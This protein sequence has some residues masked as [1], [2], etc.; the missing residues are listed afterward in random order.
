MKI[1]IN[2]TLSDALES[3]GYGH[4]PSAKVG[5]RDI[6]MDG[7]VVSPG[8]LCSSAWE[9]L[10]E[11]HPDAFGGDVLEYWDGL[12]VAGRCGQ[13]VTKKK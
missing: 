5:T 6:T 3:L 10:R 1:T 13:P 2:T 12:S 8:H 4:Q 7:E 9:W 11:R